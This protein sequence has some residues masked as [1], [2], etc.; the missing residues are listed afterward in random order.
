MR[1]P[2]FGWIA[3]GGYLFNLL[4]NFIFRLLIPNFFITRQDSVKARNK[5]ITDSKK[6]VLVIV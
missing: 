2:H 1:N 4:K 6:N 5:K 3:D